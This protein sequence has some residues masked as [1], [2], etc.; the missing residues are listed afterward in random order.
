MNEKDFFSRSKINSALLED[1]DRILSFRFMEK[2]SLQ[3]GKLN[4]MTSTFFF[5][6]HGTHGWGLRL[7]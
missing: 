5:F 6:F 4:S 3:Q 2:E 1:A 7:L